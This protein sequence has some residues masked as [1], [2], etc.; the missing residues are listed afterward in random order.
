[1]ILPI[2]ILS[3]YI[4][5][6][7]WNSFVHELHFIRRWCRIFLECIHGPQFVLHSQLLPQFIHTTFFQSNC[8][9]V[10]STVSLP[11][12]VFNLASGTTFIT[13]NQ[14]ESETSPIFPAIVEIIQGGFEKPQLSSHKDP[15]W[16]L[17]EE[18]GPHSGSR[19]RYLN[20]GF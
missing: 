15:N 16:I 18:P 8:K 13:S 19:D 12:P 4:I 11:R 1:M 3:I 2:F 14:G 20:T 5:L 7:I 6:W 10:Y 17:A 9:L